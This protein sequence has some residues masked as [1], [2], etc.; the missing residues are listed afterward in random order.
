[1]A[2]AKAPATATAPASNASTSPSAKRVSAFSCA[3]P[4]ATRPSWYLAS[5]SMAAT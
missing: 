3:L 2:Q 4:S 5:A 1:M